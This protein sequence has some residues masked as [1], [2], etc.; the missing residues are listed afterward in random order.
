MALLD[1][2]GAVV[3][4]Y[5][6][7]AYGEVTIFEADSSATRATSQYNNHYTYTGRRL[8]DETGLFYFRNRMYHATLGRFISR[9]PAGFLEGMN[10]YASYFAI[11]STDPMGLWSW[12]SFA[13]GLVRGALTAV[14]V[15]AL[16]AAAPAAVG[17]AV[18]VAGGAML[19]AGV[20]DLAINGKNMSDEE[21]SERVGELAGGFL[22]GGLRP[23]PNQGS[24]G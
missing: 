9:D 1:S 5:A 20:A 18:A 14:A 23:G 6:Y 13:K 7:G 21:Y 17:A 16:V 2:L 3:E 19:A 8:D 24:P 12:R 15:G 4:R 10:L 11:I 22:G